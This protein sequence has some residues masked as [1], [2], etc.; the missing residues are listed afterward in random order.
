MELNNGTNLQEQPASEEAALVQT[1][2][3]DQ[4]ITSYGAV[5]REYVEQLIARSGGLVS[6]P[7]KSIGKRILLWVIGM[8]GAL[9]FLFACTCFS[10]YVFKYVFPA[11]SKA[12]QGAQIP[13]DDDFSFYPDGGEDKDDKEEKE[14]D[15]PSSEPSVSNPHTSNAGLGVVVSE[16]DTELSQ[17]YGIPGG[18]VI[19][20]I[21]ENT[22]FKGADVREFDIITAAE[23]LEITSTSTLSALLNRHQI[24]DEFTVTITRFSDGFPESFDITVTLIDKT[25]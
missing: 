16:L 11:S 13:Y 1:A 20:G 5:S 10:I 3:S 8:I 4:L 15:T 22:A 7:K 18:L 9:T 17:N 14:D 23:G 6:K 21:P 12:S 25:A 19:I 24:G 2:D